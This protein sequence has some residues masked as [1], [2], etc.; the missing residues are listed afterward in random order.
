MAKFV[1][2]SWYFSRKYH[3]AYLEGTVRTSQTMLFVHFQQQKVEKLVGNAP[4]G[5]DRITDAGTG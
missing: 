2:V 4:V 3:A 1:T 5:V